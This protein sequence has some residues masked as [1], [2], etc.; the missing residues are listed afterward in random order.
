MNNKN[1]LIHTQNWNKKKR[2]EGTEGVKRRE[3]NKENKETTKSKREIQINYTSDNLSSSIRTITLDG[4]P[5]MNDR[6]VKKRR[7]KMKKKSKQ[8]KR[9]KSSKINQNSNILLYIRHKRED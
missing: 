2:N 7:R 6:Q 8:P 5:S 9:K 4:K 3:P 1:T